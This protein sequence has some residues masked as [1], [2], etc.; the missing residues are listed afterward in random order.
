[1]MAAMQSLINRERQ[2]FSADWQVYNWVKSM[3]RAISSVFVTATG[4][5]LVSKDLSGAEVGL[6]LSFA[7]AASQGG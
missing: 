5:W 2:A 3:I 4:F 7:V 6:I 1:M